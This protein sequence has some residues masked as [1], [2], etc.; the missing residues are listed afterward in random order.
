MFDVSF[1][2]LAIILVVGLLVL[3]PERLPAVARQLGSWAGKARRM[4]RVL[5]TQ[6]QDEMNAVDPR[7]IMDPPPATT[8]Y[9]RPGVDDLKPRDV[10]SEEAAQAAARDAQP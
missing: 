6:I 5:T 10:A 8:A 3:G 2:E 7:R 4:A 9:N 1:W